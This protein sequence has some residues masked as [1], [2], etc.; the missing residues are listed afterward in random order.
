MG[1]VTYTVTK[2][3]NLSSPIQLTIQPSGP[4]PAFQ[5]TKLTVSSGSGFSGGIV[6]SQHLAAITVP[7]IEFSNLLTAI[8]DCPVPPGPLHVT[9]FGNDTSDG[10]TVTG[11]QLG[12]GA[13]SL[14]R[15]VPENT[16]NMDRH[17][18]TIAH[19]TT[20]IAHHAALM[21]E[22][23]SVAGAMLAQLCK[24]NERLEC[25]EDLLRGQ[26]QYSSPP[27]AEEFGT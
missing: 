6:R 15:H 26:R 1:Q 22:Q 27:P 12:D 17:T 8:H 11:W 13:L 19:Q 25:V 20:T 7:A 16:A 21:S 2:C 14:F 5:Q 18:A 24:I 10:L 23:L 4:L 9:L 3:G